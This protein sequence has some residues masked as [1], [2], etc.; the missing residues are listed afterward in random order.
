VL[1]VVRSACCVLSVC[2][3]ACAMCGTC[4]LLHMSVCMCVRCHVAYHCVL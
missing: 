1:Y 4:Y 3:R 2:P